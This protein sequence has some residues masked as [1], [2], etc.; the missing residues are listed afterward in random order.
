MANILVK[1]LL[2]AVVFIDKRFGYDLLPDIGAPDYSCAEDLMKKSEHVPGNVNS[3][4]NGAGALTPLGVFLQYRGLSFQAGGDANLEEHITI[5]NILKKYNPDLF[6]YST[7]IGDE[8]NYDVARLNVAVAGALASELPR[9]AFHLERSPQ[10]ASVF[11]AE[12]IQIIYDN[13][14]RVIVSLT[15]VF[16]LEIL[17]E[18]DRGRYFCSALHKFQCPCVS[19]LFVN[20]SVLANAV[21]EYN[22]Y[23]MQMQTS[24]RFEKD[25]FTLVVQP[26]LSNTTEPSRINGEFNKEF[27]APDCFHFSQWGHAL[28]ASHLW[29]NIIEPVGYKSTT[30]NL[31]IPALP[32]SCPEKNCPFF[33]TPKNSVD[34]SEYFTAPAS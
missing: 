3:A 2:C 32:L 23:E 4:G 22:Y 21:N 14:P 30:V 17:R 7:G 5:P 19:D 12:A 13:V 26:F 16:H 20:K 34:C 10:Y 24:G 33:R 11:I 31:T 27:F 9:Q 18:T 6:G 25:D 29:S 15:N 8:H 28:I 1:L